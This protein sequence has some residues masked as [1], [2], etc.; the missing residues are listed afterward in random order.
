M[1]KI[2]S[3]IAIAIFG[4][5]VMSCGCRETENTETDVV[6]E[7]VDSTNVEVADSVAV[8]TLVVAE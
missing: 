3:F 7:E 8:D 5:M 1:K 6:V 4:I 2:I